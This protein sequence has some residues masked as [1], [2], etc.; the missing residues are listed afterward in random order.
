MN[1]GWTT[2]IERLL[3]GLT[4]T[5]AHRGLSY[6][7]GHKNLIDALK[8]FEPIPKYQRLVIEFE[9]GEDPDA[10]Y[11]S[12]PYEKGANLLLLIGAP[13][14]GLLLVLMTVSQNKH[15]GALMFYF[16]ISGNM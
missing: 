10:A 8:L 6:A 7:I 9:V 1:E 2:Y 16:H 12:V 5:P 3:L 4:Y 11:S 15:W 13:S 14:I